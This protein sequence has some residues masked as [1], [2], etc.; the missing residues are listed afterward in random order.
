MSVYLPMDMGGPYPGVRLPHKMTYFRTNQELVGA[1]RCPTTFQ[2]VVLL[3]FEQQR[4]LNMVNISTLLQKAGKLRLRLDDA[5]VCY[6]AL[7]LHQL[8]LEEVMTGQHVG[9]SLYGLQSMG[10]SHAVRQLL[11]ALAIAVTRC[12]ER[13]V[14]QAVGNAVYGL[15]RM[16][17][18][19]ELRELVTVLAAKIE[20][21]A[22]PFNAQAIGNALYGLQ[23]MGDTPESRRLLAVLTPKVKQFQDALSAQEV[24][25]AIHGLQRFGDSSEARE[26]VAALIPLVKK[27][28]TEFKAQE[29]SNSFH[30]LQNLGDTAEVRELLKELTTKMQQCRQTMHASEIGKAAYGL[31]SLKDSCEARQMLAALIPRLNRCTDE[32]N[33][34]TFNSIVTGIQG[35]GDSTE[36]RQILT[37]LTLKLEQNKPTMTNPCL[38][39]RAF[40]ALGKMSE[41]KEVIQLSLE[42]IG[43]THGVLERRKGLD[44][45]NVFAELRNIASSEY[46]VNDVVANLISKLQTCDEAGGA[47]CFL[48]DIQSLNARGDILNVS[49]ACTFLM[50]SSTKGFHAIPPT[51]STVDSYS[52][53]PST[54]CSHPSDGRG[55]PP[56]KGRLLAALYALFAAEESLWNHEAQAVPLGLREV[57]A[58]NPHAVGRVEDP[59]SLY[60][61]FQEQGLSKAAV[62]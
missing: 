41:M 59:A 48:K 23:R 38:V 50:T 62:R 49:D 36:M 11:S 19:D 7:A 30:G 3:I 25:N 14:P 13:L 37:A 51:P 1:S 12:K 21:Y 60:E 31:R 20:R 57:P 54:S 29:I 26:I 18:S 24:G 4:P 15:Q 55:D 40:Y 6:I 33:A 52:D 17:D 44:V 5:M 39:G 61:L 9:N 56:G 45:Y 2:A 10:N 47:I 53:E 22:E 16:E 8:P 58:G 27:C 32:I 34:T 35:L 42:L 43:M 28:T 46:E